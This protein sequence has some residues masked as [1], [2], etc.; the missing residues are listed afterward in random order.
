MSWAEGGSSL[1]NLL[2]AIS[3]AH[4]RR[5]TERNEIIRE[6]TMMGG[7]AGG[8]PGAAFLRAGAWG[9]GREWRND[10]GSEDDVGGG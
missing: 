10:G 5:E 1:P 9:A 2:E 3:A 4:G 8:L 7:P 6:N